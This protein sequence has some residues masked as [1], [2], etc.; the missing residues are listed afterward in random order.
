MRRRLVGRAGW[1]KVPKSHALNC[2]HKLSQKR[3]AWSLVPVEP[4]AASVRS[5][6]SYP[7]TLT[8]E[9]PQ[10]SP[11][12]DIDLLRADQKWSGVA[13][14]CAAGRRHLREVST[15]RQIGPPVMLQLVQHRRWIALD[16]RSAHAYTIRSI[17]VGLYY[18]GQPRKSRAEE[19]KTSQSARG[20]RPVR[21]G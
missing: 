18:A 21:T 5:R 16:S 8:K 10:R 12:K 3:A 13:G 20:D 17:T 19:K 6:E 14:L 1:P 9:R 11:P 15:C 4:S 2:R 7:S